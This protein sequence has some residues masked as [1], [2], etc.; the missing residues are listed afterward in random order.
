[1]LEDHSG[2]RGA[3]TEEQLEEAEKDQGAENTVGKGRA[4]GV[5]AVQSQWRW[6][7][8]HVREEPQE[9]QSDWRRVGP[10]RKLK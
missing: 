7:T 1:M 4:G 3:A 9:G 10:D 2:G 6:F 5:G 8:T